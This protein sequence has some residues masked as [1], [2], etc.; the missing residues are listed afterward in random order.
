MP[1]VNR[2]D[3]PAQYNPMDTYVP[4]PLKELMGS[5]EHNQ[6]RTEVLEDAT[7]KLGDQNLGSTL[8]Y[9]DR[10]G[11][12]RTNV[13]EISGAKKAQETMQGYK[14]RLNALVNHEGDPL[15]PIRRR[16][17][18]KLSTDMRSFMSPEGVGGQAMAREKE[19]RQLESEL[20]RAQIGDKPWLALPIRQE[21]DRFIKDGGPINLGVSAMKGTDMAALSDD[22]MRSIGS[23]SKE[24]QTWGTD[25][26]G[27]PALISSGRKEI[28]EDKIRSTAHGLIN[29][30]DAGTELDAI[31]KHYT[32]L[33]REQGDENPEEFGLLKRTER[34]KQI[35]DGLVAKY[36]ELATKDGIQVVGGDGPREVFDP[37]LVSSIDDE[38][39]ETPDQFGV[40][41]DYSSE[42]KAE[43]A[44]LAE[45]YRKNNPGWD[46][47]SV[48]EYV[49][50]N[51]G[52]PSDYKL[53]RKK[54]G[55]DKWIETYNVRKIAPEW[56]YEGINYEKAEQMYNESMEALKSSAGKVITFKQGDINTYLGKYLGTTGSLQ[57][58]QNHRNP[59]EFFDL[60]TDKGKNYLKE[61]TG[62]DLEDFKI[63]LSNLRKSGNSEGI[64]IQGIPTNAQAG[65]I[66]VNV[67]N[68]K[69]KQGGMEVPLNMTLSNEFTKT[70]AVP[71]MLGQAYSRGVSTQ[72]IYGGDGFI[73]VFAGSEGIEELKIEPFIRKNESG[74][75]DYSPNFYLRTED[76]TVKRLTQEE[77]IKY[78]EKSMGQSLVGA[79]KTGQ[80]QM[81]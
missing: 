71:Q 11:F 66:R 67:S 2:F 76:G 36:K 4:L 12:G 39:I 9:I 30:S 70:M 3:T 20:H 34:Y 6:K 37:A 81:K 22:L 46:N 52:S 49:Q 47:N 38:I 33:A 51:I 60:N 8:S 75:Y 50:A 62:W 13:S 80:F 40:N 17:I 43:M 42:Y 68:K 54:D 79:N 29:G 31:Q 16:E 5:I 28:T 19:Y 63:E 72:S 7:L 56:I 10:P 21:L 27:N 61:I 69:R 24:F 14:D 25:P 18:M 65:S 1:G 53:R 59:S 15:D 26:F 48:S 74:K 32:D 73:P 57:T 44:R 55:L 41:S 78:I 77:G 23:N 64:Y 45:S 35:E 58:I